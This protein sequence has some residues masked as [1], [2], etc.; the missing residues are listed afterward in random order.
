[1]DGKLVRWSFYLSSFY[2]RGDPTGSPFSLVFHLCDRGQVPS[3]FPGIHTVSDQPGPVNLESL[4]F[5][6]NV[7][8]LALRVVKERAYLYGSRTPGLQSLEQ[9]RGSKTCADDVLHDDHMLP[10]DVDVQIFR[11]PDD[12][13]AAGGIWDAADGDHVHLHRKIDGAR[14]VCAEEER[15]L[16][17]TEKYDLLSFIVSCDL[18]SEFRYSFAQLL[19]RVNDLFI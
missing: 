11:D 8:E 17:N 19:L 5:H 9:I 15:A 3:V 18:L 7:D 1:M 6:R 14:Q 16:K 10:G 13:G 4:V 2:V 12:T